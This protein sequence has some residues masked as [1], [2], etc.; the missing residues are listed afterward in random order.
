MLGEFMTLVTGPLPLNKATAALKNFKRIQMVKRLNGSIFLGNTSTPGSL[1]AP[2][3]YCKIGSEIGS[4]RIGDPN[5][6]TG[7]ECGMQSVFV[8][9]RGIGMR[10]EKIGSVTS[11]R[12]SKKFR[13]YLAIFGKFFT[14]FLV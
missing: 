9:D 8:L 13:A 11:L 1:F 14:F 5:L 12:K 6:P 10:S 3:L 2:S 4:D 7:M